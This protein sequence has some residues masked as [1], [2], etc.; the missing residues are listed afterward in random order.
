L[1]AATSVTHLHI[2]AVVATEFADLDG[3]RPV[4]VLDAGCG[5][6]GLMAYLQANLAPLHPGIEFEVH[7]FDVHDAQM[8]QAPSAEAVA[9]NLRELSPEESWDGRVTYV[10][11]ADPW[12]Y[13]DDHFD[14]VVTNQVV[15][16][17]ADLDFFLNELSRTMKPGSFSVHVFPFRRIL[18]EWHLKLPLVHLID[19][20]R[21]R[22]KAIELLTRA[23]LGTFP[24]FRAL[25][26]ID[27]ATY[28]RTRAD[29][30]QFGT[31][32]RSWREVARAA[33]IAGLRSTHRYTRELP[34]QKL[35]A[36]LS[37]PATYRY[38]RR[39]IP[40]GE[41]LSFVLLPELLTAT[42][43]LEK[44]PFPDTWRRAGR[45]AARASAE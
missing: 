26:G 6:G 25:D 13:D 35:R 1:R 42:I 19:D 27:E 10:S 32:Y 45:R 40:L 9:A 36:V 20:F 21:L 3:G 7:G 15:E 37:R 39:P 33:K 11:V 2:L 28:G 44:P 30:I 31:F 24:E 38:P 8:E 22:A 43:L 4:R 41:W 16:H 34:T 12:P 29:F 5:K 23:G 17:V 14:I 18:Y